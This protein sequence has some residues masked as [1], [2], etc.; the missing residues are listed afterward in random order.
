VFLERRNPFLMHVRHARDKVP[1]LGERREG[2][3]I[4]SSF[5]P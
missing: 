4:S 2:S 1:G 5:F 3:E